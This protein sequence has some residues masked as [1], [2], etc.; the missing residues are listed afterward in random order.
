MRACLVTACVGVI[1]MAWPGFAGAQKRSA[2]RHR[3]F[4]RR[5]NRHHHAT[6]IRRRTTRRRRCARRPRFFD[7]FPTTKKTET[8]FVTEWKD[9][10]G[11]AA[12]SE[13]ALKNNPD[14]RVAEVK[15]QQAE[16]EL[17]RARMA[18]VHKI[19]VLQSQLRSARAELAE[20]EKTYKRMKELNAN[21]AISAAELAQA[22]LG[23]MTVK[24]K[25]TR[26]KPSSRLIGKVTAAPGMSSMSGMQLVPTMPGMTGTSAGNVYRSIIGNV[27]TGTNASRFTDHYVLGDLVR[28]LPNAKTD[29]LRS[30]LQGSAKWLGREPA[31]LRHVVDDLRALFPASTSKS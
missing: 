13:Q 28:T 30:L 10:E 4:S 6:W 2:T 5:A 26:S 18:A 24:E 3:W 22:A 1:L 9:D 11:L 8:K 27:S 31:N 14:I 12:L 21:H 16:A 29:K 19:V 15:L 23:V 20:A 7:P 25:V 17:N